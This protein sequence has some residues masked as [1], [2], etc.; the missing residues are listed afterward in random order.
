MKSFNIQN[1][2]GKAKY[3]VNHHDGQKTHKDGSPFF[4]VTIFSNK[5]KLNKFVK[6]LKSKDYIEA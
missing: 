3:V 6:E 1:N 4:D 5:E 2:I